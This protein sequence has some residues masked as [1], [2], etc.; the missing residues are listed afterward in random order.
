[1]SKIITVTANTALDLFL[2]VDGLTEKDNI[3]ADSSREF[4]CGKGVNVARAIAAQGSAVTCLG[5]VGCQSMM[6]FKALESNLLHTDLTPVEGKTR[7]N[8]TLFDNGRNRETHIRTAGYSVTELDCRELAA[9]LEE[10]L[11]PKDIV[12]F[13]GSLPPGAPDDLYAYLISVCKRNDTLTI[14]D[15]SGN[16]LKQSLAAKPYLI[17]P[18][19]QELEEL[20]GESLNNEQAIVEAARYWVDQGITWVYVSRGRQGV[21]AVGREMALAANITELPDGIMTHIGC[22]DAMVAGL[23]LAIAA[24][25]NP[26][27]TL[28]RGVACGVANL[29]D[30]EPGTFDKWLQAELQRQ[31]EIHSL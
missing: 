16:S 8:I 10:T 11:Q 18:N 2:E 26:E 3:L 28:M 30:I 13:S 24:G 6:T 29:Y 22:G 21:I 7:T 1:M 27:N 9:K 14:L 19:Q 23:A 15:S 25:E 5:F 17:K 20:V 12:V 4:A 31:V